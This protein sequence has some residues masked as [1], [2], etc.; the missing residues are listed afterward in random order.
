V[1]FITTKTRFCLRSTDLTNCTSVTCRRY[2]HILPVSR[3]TANYGAA[4]NRVLAAFL[5][6]EAARTSRL[7]SSQGLSGRR[8]PRHFLWVGAPNLGS[9]VYRKE[10]LKKAFVLRRFRLTECNRLR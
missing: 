7:R 6:F 9:C 1:L 5:S 10:S 8:L 3:H 4:R 2:V